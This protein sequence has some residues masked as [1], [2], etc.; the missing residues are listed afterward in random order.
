M[1]FMRAYIL[2]NAS[3]KEKRWLQQLFNSIVIEEYQQKYMT[4]VKQL[5]LQD[6]R[7]DWIWRLSERQESGMTPMF[8]ASMNEE[9]F[10]PFI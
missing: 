4:E 3:E 2:A 7:N 10:M 5:Y 9:I 6:A 8:L 1:V